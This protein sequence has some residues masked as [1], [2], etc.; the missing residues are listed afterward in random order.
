MA[1][2]MGKALILP[3]PSWAQDD[4][5]GAVF[6]RLEVDPADFPYLNQV[7]GSREGG[8][9]LRSWLMYRWRWAAKHKQETSND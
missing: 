3:E 5:Q 6:D 1:A 7:A 4:A 9:M 8:S 2:Q